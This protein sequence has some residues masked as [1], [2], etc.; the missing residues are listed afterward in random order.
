MMTRKDTFLAIL[1]TFIWGINFSVIKL[2]LGTI[3]P[4]FLAAIRFFLTAFPLIFFVPK[5]DVKMSVVALYGFLFGI[6]L[7]GVVNIGIYLGASAGVASL[8]LQLNAYFTII[9]GFFLFAEKLS[10][11]QLIGMAVSLFGLLLSII[12]KEASSSVFSLLLVVLA[13]LSMGLCNVIAKKSSPKNMLSFLVWSSLFSPLPLLLMAYVTNDSFSLVAAIN[14]I[15]AM[16]MFSVLFQVYVTTL[17]GYWVWIS[18][19]KKYP[20]STVAPLSLM[21]PIFGF[22]GS[23]LLFNESM[24]MM[25][26][27]SSALILLGLLLFI[28]SKKLTITM[29][30]KE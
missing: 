29:G 28:F 17:F 7:W 3:D 2:G 5:P 14:G 21:V 10:R 30:E 11:F 12:Y 16:G 20:I 4:F 26:L 6:G 9:F 23:V 18:L 1:I 19:L 22:I 8:L 24:T 13:A 27:V 25:K 15:D